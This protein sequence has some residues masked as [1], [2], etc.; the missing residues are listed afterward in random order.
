MSGRLRAMIIV[1]MS[2][3]L[4]AS[5]LLCRPS[6]AADAAP[7][8]GSYGDLLI[9][10]DPDSGVLTGFEHADQVGAG[11]EKAPQFTCLFAIRGARSASG[12]YDI[13]AWLPG[14]RPSADSAPSGAD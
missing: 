3:T 7:Q 14:E 1:G 2:A 13:V 6:F 11:T 10:I 9:A 5:A 12:G 4:A 8:S